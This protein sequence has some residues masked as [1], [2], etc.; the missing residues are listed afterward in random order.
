MGGRMAGYD[1]LQ[2]LR[3]HLVYRLVPAL[4]TFLGIRRD[5]IVLM[6][7]LSLAAGKKATP[8]NLDVITDVLGLDQCVADRLLSIYPD[9]VARID[10]CAQFRAEESNA[11][12]NRVVLWV[13][14]GHYRLYHSVVTMAAR[15]VDSGTFAPSIWRFVAKD[16]EPFLAVPTL[17]LFTNQAHRDLSRFAQHHAVLRGPDSEGQYIRETLD[18]LTARTSYPCDFRDQFIGSANPLDM[19]VVERLLPV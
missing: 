16:S 4:E 1:A 6:E 9:L 3:D 11:F 5:L 2:P 14:R 19:L 18:A 7:L 12:E 13:R 17:R 8:V 15:A 10:T